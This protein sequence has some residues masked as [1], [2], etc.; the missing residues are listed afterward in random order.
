MSGYLRTS[1]PLPVAQALV[2][3]AVAGGGRLPR[4]TLVL[5]GLV[6]V[7]LLVVLAVGKHVISARETG[8]DSL[9]AL[10]GG[11]YV[12]VGLV[13]G[14]DPLDSQLQTLATGYHVDGVVNLTGPNVAEQV[15]A[16]ALSEAYLFEPVASG[17]APTWPQLAAL[18]AFM[19][20]R[21]GGVRTVYLHDENG[22]G[23][24]VVTAQMLLLLRGDTAAQAS[25]WLTAAER[26]SLRPAQSRAIAQLSSALARNANA[27]RA[28]GNQPANPY[29]AA[30]VTDW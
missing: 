8:P 9:A 20:A 24:A 16:A 19:R 27:A 11:R 26:H 30:I 12:T 21:A 15:T 17:A 6:A 14:G 2:E 1:T 29:A 28:T 10:P 3:P 13:I 5:R 4:R 23:A 7:L 18:A 22:G 25:G